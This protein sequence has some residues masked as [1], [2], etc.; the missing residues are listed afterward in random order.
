MSLLFVIDVRTVLYQW[1]HTHTHTNWQSIHAQMRIAPFLNFAHHISIYRS[2]ERIGTDLCRFYM[3]NFIVVMLACVSKMTRTKSCNWMRACQCEMVEKTRNQI[4]LLPALHR[5]LKSS[6]LCIHRWR[7]EFLKTLQS[8]AN[9]FRRY[10]RIHRRNDSRNSQSYYMC[11]GWNILKTICSF[12]EKF[13][14]QKNRVCSKHRPNSIGS[15]LIYAVVLC[16]LHSHAKLLKWK[17][18]DELTGE[19]NCHTVWSIEPHR[20]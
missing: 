19:T 13:C 14:L 10:L 1:E 20:T 5:S 7:R 16:T 11:L 8:N 17:M 15:L 3:L 12:V 9:I 4:L 6:I 18:F 2:C